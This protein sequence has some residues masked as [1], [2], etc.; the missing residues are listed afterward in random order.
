MLRFI[1]S[2]AM[3]LIAGIA[4]AQVA[5]TDFA[6]GGPIFIHPFGTG[7]N[8]A[9][10]TPFNPA[11]IAWS[12]NSF[13]GAGSLSGELIDFQTPVTTTAYDGTFFGARIVGETFGIGLEQQV[14]EDDTGQTADD[15]TN[16]QV[17]FNLGGFLALGLGFETI[18]S[19]A[20]QSTL[21]R[22]QAGVSLKLGE[23][24]YLGAGIYKDT[25][26]ITGLTG[27]F[28]RNV[29]LMG[30]AIRTEGDWSWYLGYDVIDLDNFDLGGGLQASG[31]KITR[32]TVQLLAGPVL[33]GIT[34]GDIVTTGNTGGPSDIECTIFDLGY[35]PAEGLTLSLRLQ[36]VEL[37]DATD[38]TAP[39]PENEVETTS[40]MIS[41]RFWAI[42]T[43]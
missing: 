17:S 23:I 10:I 37:F 4:Q 14:I 18:E 36:T 35:T 32:A 15:N 28:D 6:P 8:G 22:Q 11:A 30:A 27:S 20:S 43:A 25:T 13:V 24:F 19:D 33:L 1:I 9:T 26:E 40:A 31:G 12:Q 2:F 41:W 39:S 16:V 3:I 21:D 38:P 29:S 34:R 5:T 7:F 42:S